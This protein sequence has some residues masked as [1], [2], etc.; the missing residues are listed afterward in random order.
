[1]DTVGRAGADAVIVS[2]SGTGAKPDLETLGLV[3]EAIGPG[4]RLVIGS[5][6]TA[7]NL[8]ELVAIADTVI[9]G[10]S[11]K[12]DGEAVNRIDPGRA[13]A[14]VEAARTAGLL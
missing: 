2:G 7:E 8:P 1:M 13:V 11:L 12:R 9:V 5:G 3:R 10:S 6:A 14:F 4:V